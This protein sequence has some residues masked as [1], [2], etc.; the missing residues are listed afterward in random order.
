MNR[1]IPLWQEHIPGFDPLLGQPA[2]SITLYPAE[3]A[4]GAVLVLPGG[5]YQY[6]APHEG[7]PVA[8][9]FNE[10]GYFAAVLDYRVTPYRAPVPQW[11]ALRAIQWLRFLAPEYGYRPDRVAILGFSAGGHLAASAACMDIALPNAASADGPAGLNPRPDAAILCYPV[12]TLGE[13]THEGSRDNLLGEGA[14][15]EAIQRWS[16][17]RQL[18]PDAPPV[19]LWHTADDGAVPVQN[20]L[21]LAQTLAEKRIP[22]SLHVWPHGHHGLGLAE[23]TD[24]IRRWPDLAA[25]WLRQLGF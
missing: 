17:E 9:R 20:S 15:P 7:E 3:G 22:F 1:V 4:K 24:D 8:R 25:E 18:S 14:T 13:Y 2:P 12:I 21:M 16:V 11:D 5:G 6:K 23:E 19:F 10:A